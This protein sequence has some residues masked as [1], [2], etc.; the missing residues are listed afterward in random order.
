RH[1]EISSLYTPET[2]PVRTVIWARGCRLLSRTAI[3]GGP[4][5]NSMPISGR[6]AAGVSHVRSV[7]GLRAADRNFVALFKG[8]ASPALPNQYVR[9]SELKIPVDHFTGVVFNVHIKPR[10][11]ISPLDLGHNAFQGD[12]LVCVVFG[13]KRVVRENRDGRN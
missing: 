13:R 11:R 8:P 10:V 9:A 5:E 3:F 6:D 1:P 2:E 7:L 12:R 4:G